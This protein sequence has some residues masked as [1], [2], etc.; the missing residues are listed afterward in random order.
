MNKPLLLTFP[1]VLLSRLIQPSAAGLLTSLFSAGGDP[2][3]QTEAG[4]GGE[5]EKRA[6]TQQRPSGEPGKR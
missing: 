4:E 3:A 5:R 6:E 1:L 2:A